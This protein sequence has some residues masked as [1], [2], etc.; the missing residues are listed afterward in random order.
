MDVFKQFKEEAELFFVTELI[1]GPK[2]ER[3]FT[4]CLDIVFN[5]TKSPEIDSN[6]G[7]IVYDLKYGQ[8][9]SLFFEVVQHRCNRVNGRN[10][11]VM[12]SAKE[13]VSIY[14]NGGEAALLEKIKC[15][16]LFIDDIGD[17]GNKGEPKIFSY[18]HDKLNVM[19]FVL[20]KRYEWWLDKKLGWKTYGT[21]NLSIDDIG[22]VYDGR[23]ADRL[24]QMVYIEN[25]DFLAEGKSFRQMA[26]TRK[27]TPDEIRA[28]W[29]KV[30]PEKPQAEAIDMV[31]FM[32]GLL[33]EGKDYLNAM[34]SWG[35][36]T[37]FMIERGYL[38]PE[39]LG[40]IDEQKLAEARTLEVLAVKKFCKVYYI[41]PTARENAQKEALQNIKAKTVR[42]RAEM[43][44]AKQKFFTY[45]EQPGFK[46]E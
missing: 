18:Y 12:T 8:G 40:T 6:R 31:A 7:L 29:A 9:K 23:V 36:V 4:R 1:A 25:F 37:D 19:R 3:V 32:N 22:K 10:H 35:I 41:D 13:L 5:I 16:N 24:M 33:S 11:F 28:N 46:F 27:L 34:S 21:T 45:L 15:R 42:D 43:I 14:K 26:G 30:T 39:D 2:I 38:T 44:L 20:L 17:E